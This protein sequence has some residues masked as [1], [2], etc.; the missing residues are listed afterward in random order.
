MSILGLPSIVEKTLTALLSENTISS[1]KISSEGSANTVFVLRFKPTMLQVSRNMADPVQLNRT[2]R[3]QY[4]RKSPSEIHRDQER[5]RLHREKQ[6]ME[7]TSQ[8]M[9]EPF[10]FVDHS[11][12]SSNVQEIGQQVECV[13]TD[14]I[15]SD[16][17]ESEQHSACEETEVCQ[18]EERQHDLIDSDRP[19]SLLSLSQ[20]DN[21]QGDDS[22]V[23]EAGVGLR[24]YVSSLTDRSL[25]R[26]LR[27]KQQ[28]KAFRTIAIHHAENNRT[29]LMLESD[30]IVLEFTCP[31]DLEESKF[32]FYYI[33]QEEKNM[34]EEERRK[35]ANLRRGQ[36]VTSRQHHA[37]V[38]ARAT[39]ELTTLRSRI[40]FLLG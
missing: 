28:N 10:L 21:T 4:R 33:K 16:N 6:G 7:K 24:E 25:Q 31:T 9:N 11:E 14:T 12:S 37:D 23:E 18:I 35:L 3:V 29:V 39:E 30:D 8:S 17:E 26:R 1:W 36:C 22:C 27:D 38:I 5:A 19:S 2:S 32:L 20:Q 34:L 40:L 13:L 15:A